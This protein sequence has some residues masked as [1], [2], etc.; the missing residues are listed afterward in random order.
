MHAYLSFV[1]IMWVGMWVCATA[2]SPR[3]TGTLCACARVR[4]NEHVYMHAYLSFVCM[5]VG[6]WV[7]ATATS[8]RSTGTLCACA[9]VR[10]NE[11]VYMHAYLSFVCMWVG[12]WVCATASVLLVFTHTIMA[13]VH[14]CARIS[15]SLSL[16]VHIGR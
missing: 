5:W 13:S 4:G 6:M 11:H 12:M 8:P 15:L 9:R 7:C 3:S 14:V 16:Y 2:T 10:G 1:C